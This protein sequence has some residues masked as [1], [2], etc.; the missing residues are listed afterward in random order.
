MFDG[1]GEARNRRRLGVDGGDGNT[2]SFVS[3][4]V[5]SGVLRFEEA[6]QVALSASMKGETAA[7]LKGRRIQTFQS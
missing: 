6:K 7:A 3:S 5:A 2:F 1:G 4:N